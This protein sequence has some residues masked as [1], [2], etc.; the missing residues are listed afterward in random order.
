MYDRAGQKAAG[1]LG[2]RESSQLDTGN[3]ASVDHK[4]PKR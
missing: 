1:A 3:I 4:R 2:K